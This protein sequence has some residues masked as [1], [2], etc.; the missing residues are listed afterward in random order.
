MAD[1]A[2]RALRVE[3]YMVTLILVEIALSLYE[4]FV[5]S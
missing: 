5:V 2:R 3:W 1:E 4:I